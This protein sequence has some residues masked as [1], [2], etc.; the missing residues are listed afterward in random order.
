M[1]IIIM[2]GLAV[3]LVFVL[4]HR[5]FSGQGKDDEAH[6]SPAHEDGMNSETP[7]AALKS[8]LDDLKTAEFDDEAPPSL[9]RDIFSS[10]DTVYG[11]TEQAEEAEY[12]TLQLKATIIDD[13]GAL[14]IIDD[15]VMRIGQ[16]IKGLQVRTIKNNEV[17]LSRGEK[18]YTMKVTEE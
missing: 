2:A 17:I 6:A 4:A 16:S 13:Q 8:S 10:G 18:N 1:K 9:G 12:E 5:F 14:A 11:P 15:E 7:A 3:V